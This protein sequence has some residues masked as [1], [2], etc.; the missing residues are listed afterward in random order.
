MRGL[1]DTYHVVGDESWVTPSYWVLTVRKCDCGYT[2]W[3][4]KKKKTWHCLNE[5]CALHKTHVVE[6]V[7]SDRVKVRVRNLRKK[8]SIREISERTKLTQKDIYIMLCE[9]EEIT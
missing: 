2:L 7:F 6:K 4:N 3:W 1:D 9:K 5:G 8:M